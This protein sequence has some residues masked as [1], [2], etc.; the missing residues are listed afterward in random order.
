MD[1]VKSLVEEM[2]ILLKL[3][4]GNIPYKNIVLYQYYFLK[5]FGNA[6]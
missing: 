5:I 3:F 4:E 6:E 2:T 1:G